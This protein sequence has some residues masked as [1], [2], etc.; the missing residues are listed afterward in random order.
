MIYFTHTDSR[1]ANNGLPSSIQKLRCHVNYRALKY[2]A[3]IEKLGETLVSRM[4]QNGNPYLSL[5]LRFAFGRT[6]FSSIKMFGCYNFPAVTFKLQALRENQ[7][8]GYIYLS[9]W[10]YFFFNLYCQFNIMI[11]AKSF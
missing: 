10:L 2:S 6:S 9:S 11:L 1:L 7:K 4:Q 5:H 3:S 8:N